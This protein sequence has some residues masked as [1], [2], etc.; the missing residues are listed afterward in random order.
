MIKIRDIRKSFGSL[1]VLRGIDLDVGAGEVIS[2]IGP[3]GTGKSTFLRCVNYLEEPERGTIVFDDG[4]VFD[5]SQLGGELVYELRSHSSMVF[6]NFSLFA[7]LTAGEN[8]ALHLR[9]VKKWRGD[10][11]EERVAGLL[12]TMG[13]EDK[14][15]NYP[16][17]LSGGQQQR[18][19]IARAM[20]IEPEIMLF[21]EPTSSLDPELVKYVLGVIRKLAEGN[22][23]MLI[24]TH[25]MKFAQ[26][27]SDRV[28]FM[29]GGR[30]LEEG[31]P[32]DIFER[33]RHDRIKEFLDLVRES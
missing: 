26:E 5:F 30:I 21:D 16:R 15:D 31:D 22:Q 17:Q 29:E 10:E 24:V 9:K 14:R 19:A 6:Q 27:V 13:L 20:A 28:V 25:E 8:I 18:I 4:K 7:N 2:I 32:K 1:E 11:V 3:S 33:P 12:R 23:T